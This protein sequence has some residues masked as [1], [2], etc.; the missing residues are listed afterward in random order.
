[1][2]NSVVSYASAKYEKLDARDTLPTKFARL[3][4]TFNLADITEGKSVALKMHL[5]NNLGYTT[6]H[7]LFV[8]VLVDHVKQKADRVFITDLD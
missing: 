8:K 4:D 7:P 6:T 3:F 5:G 2:N 1:M